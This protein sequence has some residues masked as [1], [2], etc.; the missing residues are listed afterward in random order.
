M[1]KLFASQ[2][3]IIFVTLT[4]TLIVKKDGQAAAA[5]HLLPGGGGAKLNNYINNIPATV[6]NLLSSLSGT[7]R[8]F[9]IPNLFSKILDGFKS[10]VKGGVVSGTLILRTSLLHVS[11]QKVLV[12]SSRGINPLLQQAKILSIDLHCHCQESRII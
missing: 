7:V 6:V 9:I 2:S 5:A 1:K 8:H 3:E 11:E 12:K 4:V 10:P